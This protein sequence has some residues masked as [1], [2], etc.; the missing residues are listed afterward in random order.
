MNVVTVLGARP[1]F[2]KAAAVSRRFRERVNIREIL[3]HTGQHYDDNMSEV[4]FREL[5]LP[6]PAY[7]L[8]V[9]S[10]S[11]G[12]QTGRMLERIE[13][14]LQKERPDVVLIFGDTNSTFAGALA[15]VAGEHGVEV[16]DHPL[17]DRLVEHVLDAVGP[18]RHLAQPPRRRPLPDHRGRL[19]EQLAPVHATRRLRRLPS[20]FPENGAIRVVF[21]ES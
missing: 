12:V 2:I 9:G 6:A 8:G 4:F 3:V 20:T 11:H 17:G 21:A 13:E 19:R 16:G 10:G 5:D 14:V 1:Q 7:H 18:A 15:A